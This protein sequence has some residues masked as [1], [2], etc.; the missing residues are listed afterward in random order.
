[1]RNGGFEF[2]PEF[3]ERRPRQQ[4]DQYEREKRGDSED[5]LQIV[6]VHRTVDGGGLTY[7]QWLRK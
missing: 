6:T 2:F 3:R 1:M 5:F 4:A 7:T